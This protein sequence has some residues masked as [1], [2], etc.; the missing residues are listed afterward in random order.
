M[1]STYLARIDVMLKPLVNDP[2]GLAVR[3]SLGELGFGGVRGVRVGK[4]IEVTLEADGEAAAQ[5]DIDSMCRKLLANG[6]IE[7][8]SFTIEAA[9]EA[10][11]AS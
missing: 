7:M 1:A 9:P 3:D 4:H 8:F 11:R 10:V 6:V 2:Q 5:G